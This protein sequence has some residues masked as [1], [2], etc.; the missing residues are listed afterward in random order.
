VLVAAPRDA[1][2][3]KTQDWGGQNR[4]R[5]LHCVSPGHVL[6]TGSPEQPAKRGFTDTGLDF[7]FGQ[8]GVTHV[9]RS[10]VANRRLYRARKP[11]S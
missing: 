6:Y 8:H 10:C 1:S 9:V 5:H 2:A 4:L 3:V 11:P 7:N